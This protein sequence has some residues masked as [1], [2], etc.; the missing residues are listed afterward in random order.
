VNRTSLGRAALLLISC[1]VCVAVAEATLRVA[2][3]QLGWHPLADEVLGWSSPEYQQFDPTAQSGQARP[4]RLLVLGDSFVAGAMLS[5][6]DERFPILAARS[7]E[8]R[9]DVAIL[10]TGG[11]GTDQELLA[12]LAKGRS[13]Q[14]DVVLLAFCANNDLSNNASNTHDATMTKPYFV[15]GSDGA[16]ELFSSEGRPLDD[17]ARRLQPAPAIRSY[18]FEWIRY[19]L[20]PRPSEASPATRAGP[21]GAAVDPRYTRFDFAAEKPGELYALQP[22]LSWSPQHSVSHASAYIAGDFD[23][24]RF[25]WQLFESIVGRLQLETEAAGAEL[26]VMLLPVAFKPQ[27]PRFI[28]GGSLE[29]EFDTPDGPFRFRAAE[30]RDR[31]RAITERAGVRF[32]DPTG[33]F[34][35]NVARNRLEVRFWPNPH[36]RHFGAEG[37]AFLAGQLSRYLRSELSW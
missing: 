18:A 4:R 25:Q 6:L 21:R 14:P 10:A 24:N 9:P 23:T 2:M 27:D 11:W 16:L 19:W 37:H 30:P 17:W 34:I 5:D 13:W 3:P 29:F 36:N 22:S 35:E 28:A 31:L 1:L 33:E 12:F 20:R 15:S 7:L 32:F 8:P 26:V